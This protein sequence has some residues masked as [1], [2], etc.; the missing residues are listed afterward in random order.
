[1]ETKY[2]S[3]FRA[4]A[5]TLRDPGAYADFLRVIDK[6]PYAFDTVIFFNQFTHSIRS[7]D[8]HR[9]MA[10]FMPKMLADVRARG[11]RAGI[12]AICSV[13]FFKE[14][15]KDDVKGYTTLIH[16]NGDRVEGKICGT[17]PNNRE[18]LEGYFRIYAALRPDIMYLDDDISPMSCFCPHCMERFAK[19]H[20][21]IM[22][23]ED[24]AVRRASREEWIKFTSQ[25]INELYELAERVIRDIS[26]ETEI[27]YMPHMCG[28]DGI[29]SDT[30]VNTLSGKDRLPVACRPGGGVY[31]DNTP[32][33]ALNKANRISAQ[34]RYLP[35]IACRR[36]AEIENFPYQTLKKS[37]GF[38]AFEALIYM[39]AGCTGTAWNIAST[40]DPDYAEFEPFFEMINRFSATGKAVSEALGLKPMRGIAFPWKKTSAQS[41]AIP[42]IAYFNNDVPIAHE[43]TE[44]G[45]P[46]NNETKLPAVALLNRS[47]ALE[48]SDGELESIL[49]G[50]VY[51]DG[52]AL[53]VCNERGFGALT[54]FRTVSRH[55]EGV[56]ERNTDHKFNWYGRRIRNPRQAFL[57]G[58]G[59]VF[60]IEK[61]D[62]KAEY[63]SE[64]LDLEEN[65]LGYTV[66]IFEN[67]A[68]GRVC[69][70]GIQP[71]S[72][73]HSRARTEQLKNVFKWLSKET[74]P[75]FVSS[76][77]RLS[78]WARG[79][80]AFAAN[81]GMEPVRGAEVSLLNSADKRK[82]ILTNGADI[83]ATGTLE[84]TKTDGKYKI[85]TLPDIP[86]IGC[87]VIE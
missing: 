48:L 35:E 13:G 50:G 21:E 30:W 65:F 56:Q 58:R 44:I 82:Y 39:A 20:P 28:I 76:F 31:D 26:P 68:G 3:V 78:L 53:E 17:H 52:E 32:Y 11:M 15:F 75:A 1:M 80:S 61:T 81:F 51:M 84:A 8:Y 86:V 42:T 37:P 73:V 66:G 87:I 62:D 24:I 23:S 70:C 59:D 60:R 22:E 34:L 72:W 40:G 10:E 36:E 83:I 54:G 27:C 19:L 29:D 33:A 63:L 69:V 2:T 67:G 55:S 4:N 85:F 49:R 7:L 18:Y 16:I 47:M 45:L 38:T 12:N 79:E 6:Y 14:L 71:F 25:R 41:L 77:S 57:W 64:L 43:L 46:L 9:N 5:Y 74:L